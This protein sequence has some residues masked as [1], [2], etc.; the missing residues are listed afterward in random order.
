MLKDEQ[1]SA[2]IL[3]QRLAGLNKERGAWG[4]NLACG[5][6]WQGVLLGR[7]GVWQGVVNLAT[8]NTAWRSEFG[9]ETAR[10][11]KMG[12]VFGRG[13]SLS[14]SLSLSSLALVA[15]LWAK[16]K[17]FFAHFIVVSSRFIVDF[18]HFI[19]ISSYRK[20]FLFHRGFISYFC[21]FFS[22]FYNCL[23]FYHSFNSSFHSQKAFFRALRFFKIFKCF[24]FGLLRPFCHFE[25]F[26]KRRPNG[27]QGAVA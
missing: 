5:V 2:K 12:A 24:I 22:S 26:A 10:Q 18:A 4:E 27:L 9:N 3:P 23:S 16:L 15:R 11:S 13:T 8:H 7:S 20:F 1:K 17:G 19:A 25:H 14:L 6:A 21:S